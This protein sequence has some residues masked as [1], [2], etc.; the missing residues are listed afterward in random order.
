[1]EELAH[2]VKI[3]LEK[4]HETLE[5]GFNGLKNDFEC[6]EL[7]E[8]PVEKFEE[9]LNR[10]TNWEQENYGLFLG[11]FNIVTFVIIINDILG[12]EYKL[13]YEWIGGAD[14]YKAWKEEQD[15][16]PKNAIY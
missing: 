1:M 9:F 13:K 16:A 12:K 7:S 2:S 4:E 14:P 8:L 5:V 6:F 15:N 10:L 11:M 3:I